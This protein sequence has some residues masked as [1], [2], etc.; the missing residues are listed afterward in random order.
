MIFNTIHELVKWFEDND[1]P[2]LDGFYVGGE[3][4]ESARINDDSVDDWYLGEGEGFC[5]DENGKIFDFSCF[6]V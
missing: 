2:C 5:I 1:Y 4:L 6:S 3:L